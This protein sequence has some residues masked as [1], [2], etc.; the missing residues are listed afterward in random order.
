MSDKGFHKRYINNPGEY[1]KILGRAFPSMR[2]L[3][4]SA[5]SSKISK[6][7]SEKLFLATSLVTG[8]E[9]CTWLHTQNIL[10]QGGNQEEINGILNNDFG[11][12]SKGEFTAI[13]YM[14]HITDQ[15]G[16]PSE[17]AKDRVI[18]ELGEEYC[19]E[20]ELHYNIIILGNLSGNTME[21]FK[22]RNVKKTPG[23]IVCYII[24]CML[25]YGLR[26]LEVCWR[27]FKQ[28]ITSL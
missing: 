27:K 14:Q 18:E 8:C 13:T 1:F 23:L 10:E 20:I 21:A 19:R 11:S 16:N 25:F 9:Y 4:R 17:A 6:E 5:D 28:T 26:N 15:R 22:N 24:A 12:L 3:N 2:K 7:L